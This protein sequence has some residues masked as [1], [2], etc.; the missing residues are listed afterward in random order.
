MMAR[1]RCQRRR[2]AR[3]L[4]VVVDAGAGVAGALGEGEGHVELAPVRRAQDGLPCLGV[5]GPEPGVAAGA[6]ALDPG[7]VAASIR[8][9]QELLR[10][11]A[12]V[13]PSEELPRATVRGT[14]RTTAGC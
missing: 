4:L 11:R 7:E 8:H 10:W 9:Q 5:R 3:C 13:D 6:A 2:E 12:H 1:A 14:P